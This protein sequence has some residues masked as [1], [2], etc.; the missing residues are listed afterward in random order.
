MCIPVASKPSDVSFAA[1][2]SVTDHE[3]SKP[4]RRAA[5][6][7]R[8]S[9]L[10]GSLSSRNWWAEQRAEEFPST[11]VCDWHLICSSVYLMLH[12][13]S[14][15]FSS[16]LAFFPDFGRQTHKIPKGNY[17]ATTCAA[18]ITSQSTRV[19][20]PI[21]V[22][23]YPLLGQGAFAQH[24]DLS[25]TNLA[26]ERDDGMGLRAGIRSNRGSVRATLRVR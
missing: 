24:S 19:K 17:W 13:G 25:P 6:A 5:D 18:R 8:D 10:A 1:R 22:L 23:R 21:Y 9:K 12:Q 3:I 15:C 4:A 20:S 11:P 2:Q 14:V 16:L 26:R 7:A